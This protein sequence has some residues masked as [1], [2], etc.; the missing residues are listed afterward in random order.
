MIA[1]EQ[2]MALRSKL[3]R[4]GIGTIVALIGTLLAW[5][6]GPFL[7]RDLIRLVVLDHFLES[8]IILV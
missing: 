7:F 8:L 6:G 5:I 2:A 3:I 1:A 4:A